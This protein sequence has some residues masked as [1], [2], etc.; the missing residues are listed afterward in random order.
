M[1]CLPQMMCFPE[2]TQVQLGNDPAGPVQALVGNALMLRVAP[3]LP[4]CHPRRCWLRNACRTVPA[5]QPAP[6]LTAML[7]MDLRAWHFK[8]PLHEPPSRALRV[9]C[10]ALVHFSEPT[11]QQRIV[12][13]FDPANVS[14]KPGHTAPATAFRF[15]TSSAAQYGLGFMRLLALYLSF[16]SM[17]YAKP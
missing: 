13:R 11:Q 6:I 7:S 2:A 15:T 8:V 4:M 16:K 1:R 14:H 9:C 10:F 3:R 17:R 12:P 5:V